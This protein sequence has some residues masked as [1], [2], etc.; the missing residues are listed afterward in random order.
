MDKWWYNERVYD[1]QDGWLLWPFIGFIIIL[2]ILAN[3]P[4]FYS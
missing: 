3:L 2:F 4:S 1:S